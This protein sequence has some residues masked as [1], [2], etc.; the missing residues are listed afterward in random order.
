MPL[1]DKIAL[2][3]SL[4]RSG[5]SIRELNTVRKHLSAI[6]G[7]QLLR[8]TNGARVLSLILSD[9]PGDDLATIGSGLTAP[10]P[11]TYADAIA[12]LKRR[13][14]WGRAPE[15]IRDH[16][17]RGNAGQIPETPKS[18]DAI[19]ARVTNV[20]IGSNQTALDA[21]ETAARELGYTVDRSQ[22]L[23][24]EA[25]DLGRAL[26]THMTTIAGDRHL[27]RSREASRSSPCEAPA[28]AAARSRPRSRWRMELSRI[29]GDRRIAALFAGT[30][31]IDGPT[32]AAGAF[33]FPD[34]VARAQAAGLN[35]ETALSAQR[36]L[37]LLQ[38]HRRPFCSRQHRYQR[39]RHLHR[40]DKLPGPINFQNNVRSPASKSTRFL[41]TAR[42]HPATTRAPVTLIPG[43]GVGPEV[44][45]AAVAVVDATGVKIDWQHQFAGA[46][47]VKRYGSPAPDQLL[48]SLRQTGVALKGPLETQVGEGY[49]SINVY[50]RRELNLYANIRPTQSFPGVTHAVQEC[51]PGDR[52]REHRGPVLRHRASGRAGRG[53]ER[54][55]D[56][57]ARVAAYRAFRVRVCAQEPSQVGHRD[58]QGQHHEAL[59]WA[60][61]EVRP[62][63]GAANI[64]ISNTREQIVDAAC[65]RLVTEPTSFDM[66]LLENLYGDIVSDLCA[67]LVGGLGVVPGANYGDRGA[68]FEA[69]HGTAPDIAGKNLANPTAAI[70]SAAMMLDYLGH[71]REA[72]ACARGVKAV[73]KS[74]R[75]VTRDLGGKASTA[76]M[77]RAADQSAR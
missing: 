55:G 19:F 74:G 77:T 54:Q 57:G 24:G 33:A 59:R 52:A 38:K 18:D 42:S 50:L 22:E 26:A 2:T 35:P 43:D 41:P 27:R 37:Q 66:L 72:S 36:C 45:G 25:N 62:R 12:V 67:G 64:P 73:L 63:G 76:D 51:R 15:T 30:D 3:Q 11:T 32:D 29:A 17:E 28:K 70:L 58:P 10:D 6:K 61:S 53:R 13:Q 56:H 44:I 8:A 47:G 23:R 9:V 71:P 31:G 68:I 34:S 46:A 39:R 48:E 65:M 20:I 40:A 16:L 5:A 60:V 7:G 14:L 75:M 49:R 4:L 69:V 21:A 1:S